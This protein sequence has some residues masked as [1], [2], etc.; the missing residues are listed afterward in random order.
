MN[1]FKLYVFLLNSI[2]ILIKTNI[3]HKDLHL[4]NIIINKETK[5][6]NLID[7]GLSIDTTLFYKSN[8]LDYTY[9]KNIYID[10]D[11]SWH[12]WPIENH[13]LCFYLY[14][15]KQLDEQSLK[16]MIKSFLNKNTVLSRLYSIHDLT[17][18]MF[19][20]LKNK[21]INDITIEDKIKDI[22]DHSWK[23][24]DLYQI[25]YI[26]L[27]I[28]TLEDIKNINSFKNILVQTIHYDY[29]KRPNLNG[30]I[31]DFYMVLE[32]YN[33]NQ[34]NEKIK[35]KINRTTILHTLKTK[36]AF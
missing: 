34:L 30:L 1:I 25:S 22:L 31:S 13:I 8:E 18:K 23:T 35:N 24:W 32:H 17:N 12:Y 33:K 28:F 15:K 21:Y 5:Q 6:F 7:F 16:E 36:K 19:L 29:E 3:I 9:L 14:K 27:Y 2:K 4:G 11:P 20:F 26:L 10:Y